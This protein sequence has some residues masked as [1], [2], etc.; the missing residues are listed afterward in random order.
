MF[1][2]ESVRFRNFRVLRDVQVP[3]QR[4]TVLVGA[5]NV[6]K[7]SVLEGIEGGLGVGRRGYAFD[8]SDVSSGVD[9]AVG[10]EILMTFAPWRAISS[11]TT[12]LH[13]SEHMS[14]SLMADIASSF[15]CPDRSTPTKACFGPGCAFRSPTGGTTAG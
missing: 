8:E 11:T 7:T 12:K 4:R 13:Y 3:F 5:N 6:G 14:T 10:F 9:A 15:K 2:I 1:W